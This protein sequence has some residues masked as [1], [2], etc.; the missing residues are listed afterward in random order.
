MLQLLPHSPRGK[1]PRSAKLL[2]ALC[3]AGWFTATTQHVLLGG[4]PA[5]LQSRR[6]P[7]DVARVEV[8]IEASG[9]L[10]V[11]DNGKLRPLKMTVNGKT[12]YDEQ[13]AGIEPGDKMERTSL[14]YY[15]TAEAQ[16]GIEKGVSKPKLRDDR[17][18]ISA[19]VSSNDGALFSPAGSLTREELELIDIPGNSLLADDLLPAKPVSVGDK[20]QHPDQLLARLMGLD[21][22]SQ[23][24]VFS[25]LKQLDDQ[26]AKI[27]FAGTI[28]GALA[29]V[30]SDIDLKG[31]YLF[32]RRLN[33]VTWMALVTH[34][35]RSAGYVAQR[36]LMWT[37]GSR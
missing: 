8:Q 15:E 12:V 34:E 17:R 18:M 6:A 14:R 7:G 22:V 32:D 26:S 25:E 9:E 5:L 24:D 16:I 11:N 4:E 1:S 23:S 28:Q 27:E 3:L 33:R 35:K 21:A 10:K 20:W 37:P 29:G 19:Q 31:R 30:A 13:L 36:A 2:L